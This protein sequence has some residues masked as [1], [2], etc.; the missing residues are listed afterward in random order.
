MTPW[1]IVQA[2]TDQRSDYRTACPQGLQPVHRHLN[3]VQKQ[4][5]RHSYGS[6][7]VEFRDVKDIFSNPFQ[8]YAHGDLAVTLA[9]VTYALLRL[10]ATMGYECP[11][12]DDVINGSSGIADLSEAG[13]SV[14]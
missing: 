13:Q 3:N 12:D 7:V 4:E 10:G 6:N 5:D 9:V 8:L 11:V 14:A 2:L 1:H